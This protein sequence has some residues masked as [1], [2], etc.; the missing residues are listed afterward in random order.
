MSYPHIKF[1]YYYTRSFDVGGWGIEAKPAVFSK[2][3]CV[4]N[5]LHNVHGKR[6]WLTLLAALSGNKAKSTKQGVITLYFV[7]FFLLSFQFARVQKVR[8]YPEIL[9]SDNGFLSAKLGGS[10]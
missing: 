9:K 10:I 2:I 6:L 5:S 8:G 1:N 4:I 3:C 7:D